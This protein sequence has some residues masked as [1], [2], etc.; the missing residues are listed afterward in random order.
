MSRQ[1]Q[2]QFFPDDMMQKIKT[3]HALRELEAE[4]ARLKKENEHLKHSRAGHM[5]AYEKL[6][7]S[8]NHANDN[9]RTS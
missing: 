1:L 3:A 7:Q 8:I 9:T 4:V 5:G 2:F 6:K